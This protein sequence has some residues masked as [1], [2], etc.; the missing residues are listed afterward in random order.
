[1]LGVPNDSSTEAGG[2]LRL[3]L[4]WVEPVPASSGPG[5][6][7]PRTG[8]PRPALAELVGA[9]EHGAVNRVRPKLM[10]ALA[11]M[12]GLV[13]GLWSQGAG[14]SVMKRIA[15]PMVGGMVT[16]TIL[17]LIVSPVIYFLL[18]SCELRRNR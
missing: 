14:A 2:L 17:T 6:L 4:L 16:S 12:L 11:I 1:M 15:A 9:I 18:R 13:P 10:T 7:T 8:C 5:G 3:L